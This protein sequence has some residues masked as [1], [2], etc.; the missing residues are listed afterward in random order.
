MRRTDNETRV[1][2]SVL[3]RLVDQDPRS[4]TEAPK[5]RSVSLAELKQSVRRDLEWLLNSRCFLKADEIDLEETKRSVAFYGL[6]DIT[7]LSVKDPAA[8]KRLSAAVQTA[9]RNFEPRFLDLRITFE[10][11]SGTDNRMHF[12]IEANLDMDPT[13]EPIMFDT[14]LQV[15]DANFTVNE[16]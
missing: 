10:P 1:T 3:D 7:G 16:R 8:L 4:S 14:V 5:S 13:P 6:P 11:P 9:I 15:A 2:P 12:R